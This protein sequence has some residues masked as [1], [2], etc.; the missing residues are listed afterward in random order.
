MTLGE[1]LDAII[2]IQAAT[3]ESMEALSES[4][5]RI[6]ELCDEEDE[7]D[8]PMDANEALRRDVAVKVARRQALHLV[9]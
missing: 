4:L 6:A 8:P 5:A 1:K 7:D 3:A 9:K 2:R